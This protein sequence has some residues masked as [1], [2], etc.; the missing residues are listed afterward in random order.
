MPVDIHPHR[1]DDI[2]CFIQVG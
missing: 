2:S 1:K